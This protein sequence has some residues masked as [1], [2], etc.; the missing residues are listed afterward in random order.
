MIHRAPFGSLERFIAVLIEHT[1]GRFPL[2]L[3]PD[4]AVIIPVSE[5]FGDY[6]KKVCELLNNNDIRATLDDR[7]ETLGKKIRENELK[8]IPFLLIV[9]EKE[10]ASNTVSVR[11]QGVGDEGE[12]SAKEFADKVNGECAKQLNV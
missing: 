5:K 1:A 8:R 4:Q 2:W 3:T 6:A 7:N 11:R 9:G 10:V 12:M